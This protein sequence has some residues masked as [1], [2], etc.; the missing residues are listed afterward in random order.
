MNSNA[1]YS[2][3]GSTQ[4]AFVTSAAGIRLTAGRMPAKLTEKTRPDP[5]SFM[6]ERMVC[7]RIPKRIHGL[8]ETHYVKQLTRDGHNHLPLLCA[9]LLRLIR[10]QHGAELN[11]IWTSCFPVR[12]WS[13]EMSG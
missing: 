8:V 11:V 1:F 7:R 5:T 4:L 12:K 10:W 2:P 13:L 6:F 9:G 3:L